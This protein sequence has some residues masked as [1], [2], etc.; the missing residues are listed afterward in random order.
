MCSHRFRLVPIDAFDADGN[1]DKHAD[2]VTDI[3][4]THR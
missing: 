3:V 1:V 4:V 2:T